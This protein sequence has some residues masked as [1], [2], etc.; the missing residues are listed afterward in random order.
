[1]EFE[2]SRFLCDHRVGEAHTVGCRAILDFLLLGE[3]GYRSVHERSPAD[4]DCSRPISSWSST[5]RPPRARDRSR[6]NDGRSARPA[7]DL[8]AQ[9]EQRDGAHT[10]DQDHQ[11]HGVVVQPVSALYTHEGTS[12]WRGFWVLPLIRGAKGPSRQRIRAACVPAVEKR[13]RRRKEVPHCPA[14]PWNAN[15]APHR[16]D[17]GEAHYACAPA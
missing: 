11:C 5:C 3:I 4:S 10:H 8:N 6:I 14:L 12:P 13:A 17:K 9:G 16:G 15:I 2:R 7:K 1:V